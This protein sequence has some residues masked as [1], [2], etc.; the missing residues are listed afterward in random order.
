MPSGDVL[1]AGG[2]IGGV[3]TALACA[4]QGFTVQVFEQSPEFTEVG[5]GIQLSPNCTRVLHD[6]GLES[7]LRDIAFLPEGVEMRDWRSGRV[8]SA[9]AL[10]AAAVAQYG[11]PYYN[12]HRA[13]FMKVL[14]QAALAEPGVQLH[15]NACVE[16][17]EQDAGGV[18]A[19][20]NGRSHRSAILV[21]ADG[22]HS[23]VRAGMFGSAAPTFTGNVAWRMLVPAERLAPGMLRPVA[24]AWW[25]PRKHFVHYF[26]RAGA[27]VNCVCVVEERDWQV[28]SWTQRGEHSELKDSF[29]G[30]NDTVQTLIDNADPDSCYKWALFDRPPMRQWGAGR[31]TLLGDACHPTLPFMAQG[32]AMAIEDGAVLARCLAAADGQPATALARYER[33]RRG[34]TARVQA[35]SRRNAKVYHLSGVQAWLRNLVAGRAASRE[36]DR[37]FGYDALRAAG[38]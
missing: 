1:I 18:L 13:D 32:A 38:A 8:L 36:M 17:V 25:G 37:V 11:H 7:A 31:V 16:S 10:G 21:G 30:W 23:T 27:L 14:V 24:T 5:A 22:I 28:E 3:T 29:A 4:R 33:L 15:T 2:G 9:R 26:V 34:R 19:Q 12:V 6:L 35:S 20:I